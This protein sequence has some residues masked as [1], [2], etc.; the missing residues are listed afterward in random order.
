[1][2]LFALER[3]PTQKTRRALLPFAIRKLFINTGGTDRAAVQSRPTA[4]LLTLLHAAALA[5]SLGITPC[6]FLDLMLVKDRDVAQQQPLTAAFFD[7]VARQTAVLAPILASYPAQ[8]VSPTR[9]LRPCSILSDDLSTSTPGVCA[10]TSQ[11]AA[12]ADAALT[13]VLDLAR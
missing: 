2:L 13:E 10:R 1:M 12:D 11:H 8:S 7:Q 3:S 6:M 9:N 4:L 5:D